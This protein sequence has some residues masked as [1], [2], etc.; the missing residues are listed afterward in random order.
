MVT[1]LGVAN[2]GRTA[3][4]TVE[5]TR[6]SDTTAYAAEDVISES[7]TNGVG[8]AFVF[9]MPGGKG[10]SGYIV[11]ARAQTK[12]AS[13]TAAM[14]LFLFNALPTSELDD[15]AANTAPDYEDIAGY[16]GRIDFPGMEDLGG[17]S[18]WSQATPSTSG[19]LPLRFKC[20]GTDDRLWGILVT[21]DAFTPD[22]AQK[23]SVTLEI[24]R[25]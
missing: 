5:K 9:A 25:D 7:A 20:A 8:T 24:E 18:S 14:T 4:V 23:V 12:K 11:E 22:S 3:S 10:A 13:V 21:R 17:D 16:Q 15:N 1:Q 19:Q 2:A 6:P